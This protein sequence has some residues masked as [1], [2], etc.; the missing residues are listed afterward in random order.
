MWYG[1][2][3]GVVP[4]VMQMVLLPVCPESPR[5]LLMSHQME[6]DARRGQPHTVSPFR[7]QVQDTK[8][9]G[10]S[11]VAVVKA[12]FQALGSKLL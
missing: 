7:F 9:I 10:D 3:L 4:A 12:T 8:P 2:G 6:D 1:A 11:C 5:Y